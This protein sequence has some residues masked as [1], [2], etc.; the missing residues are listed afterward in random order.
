LNVAGVSQAFSFTAQHL[1]HLCRLNRFNITSGQD[2]VLFG[3]R[4]CKIVS[5]AS[6]GAFVNSVQLSEDL[7]DH[8][9][10]HCV[11]GVWKKSTGQ[12]AVFTGSTV[13]NWGYM[14]LQVQRG[15]STANMLPTGRYR[16]NVGR[17][18]AVDGAFVLRTE[19]V[20]LRSNN[21][22]IYETTDLWDRCR[23]ADN[24]HPGF[25]PS[26]A[27]FSS[28]GCQTVSGNFTN[29][30]HRGSWATF[31]QRAGLDPNNNNDR[32]GDPFVYVLLTGREARLISTGHRAP[33]HRL[34]FG[35][36]GPAVRALQMDLSRRGRYTGTV[37]GDMGP[38][39]AMAY[40]QWQQAQDNGAADGIVTPS[41]GRSFGFD[42]IRRQSVP[43]T[44]SRSR[45][46]S[47][48]YG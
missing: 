13:P 23:P 4:G 7:P 30:R 26:F 2:Q 22:L 25:N 24:I 20:V 35:S 14:C 18:R 37:D 28:A 47:Y 16:Y 38:G 10:Y 29:G 44:G 41:V 5:G 27:E 33:L 21:N 43:A 19:V 45:E 8:F 48:E 40:I 11:L 17:H 34:R 46:H 32:F 42:M 36:Q 6:E 15:G 12:I 1:Q 31:R 9:R 39:T 3:L